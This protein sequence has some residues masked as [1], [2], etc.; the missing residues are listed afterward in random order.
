MLCRKVEASFVGKN[1]LQLGPADVKEMRALVER[2]KPGPFFARSQEL[3]N[4]IGVRVDGT[5]AA[6]AGERMHLDGYTE[7]SAVCTDPAFRGQGHARDLLVCLADAIIERGELPFLHVLDDYL[8]AIA[9]YKKLGFEIRSAMRLT[10]V[11][12]K[13][14]ASA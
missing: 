7:I 3:G 11:R 9:L 8:A 5:L 2:T 14:S 1:P 12:K 4:F 6:M 13:A 10:V